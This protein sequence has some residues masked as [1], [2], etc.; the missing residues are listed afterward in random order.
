MEGLVESGLPLP[1]S[2]AGEDPASNIPVIRASQDRVL[3]GMLDNP[4][5]FKREP[6]RGRRR[7]NNNDRR[8]GK[9]GS[10]DSKDKESF[11]PL[12]LTLFL[13]DP[14]IDRVLTNYFPDLRNDLRDVNRFAAL[15]ENAELEEG[16][17]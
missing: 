5:Y 6:L 8:S 10:S 14:E 17:F 13:S 16:F 1:A 15:L 11:L 4:S 9:S 3:R 7:A 2:L 12:N